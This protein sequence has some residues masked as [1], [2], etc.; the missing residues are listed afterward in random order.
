MSASDRHEAIRAGTRVLQIIVLALLAGVLL[1]TAFVGNRIVSGVEPAGAKEGFP[2]TWVLLGVAALQVA[3][4]AFVRMAMLTKARQ[5]IADGTFPEPP[6]GGR[7]PLAAESME[8]AGDEGRFPAA[9]EPAMT[10]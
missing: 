8:S 2:L 7:G 3:M 9:W 10:T 6:R 1:F 5:Q 4:I